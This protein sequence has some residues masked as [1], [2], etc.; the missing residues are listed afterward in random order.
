MERI[1]SQ[2]QAF[3]TTL[4]PAAA[5][6]SALQLRDHAQAILEAV[7]KDLSTL[8]TREAQIAK[9]MGLAPRLRGAP[10]TAAETHG[11]LR[12]CSGF[13]IKQLASEFRALRA[14]VLRLW[15]D[16]CQPDPPH[17]DDIVRFNEAI[18]QALAESVAF[19]SAHVERSRNLFLGMLGHDMRSPLQTI[20]V[21]AS[22]LAQLN[23]RAEISQAAAR[24]VSSGKQ[25]QALLDDLVDFNRTTLG[26]GIRIQRSRGDLA[27]LFA[28][29]MEELSATHPD[30]R[31]ELEVDGDAHG[32]W[33]VLRLRRVLRN[34]VVNA[35]KHGET[36]TPVYVAVTGEK[37]RVRF[38]V[39]NTGPNIDQ[40][41]LNQMFEPLARG[42]DLADRYEVDDGLGLGLFIVREIVKAHGGEVDARSGNNEIVF[43]V[44]LPRDR[45]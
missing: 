41:T 26:V 2:W 10:E 31:L 24:L 39:K 15:M 9:S 21:T 43:A 38:E 45:D 7:A 37:N 28:A 17:L 34:L 1:L 20:T 14:S 40:S 13:D 35:I 23:S 42:P 36:Q 27:S 18:D 6:M 8:Q 25:M 22:H 3:A 33:D 29:E 11:F 19:F 12:A 4:T 44:R 30:R 5:D 16:A 32:N